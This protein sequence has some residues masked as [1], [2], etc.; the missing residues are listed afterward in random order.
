MSVPVRD[1]LSVSALC[2]SGSVRLG[3]LTSNSRIVITRESDIVSL[4][5]TVQLF[6]T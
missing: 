3:V 4:K 5:A 6:C 1:P 2:N